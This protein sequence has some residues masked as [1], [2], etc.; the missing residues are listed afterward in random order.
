MR[1]IFPIL[2]TLLLAACSCEEARPVQQPVVD[3]KSDRLYNRAAFVPPQCYTKTEDAAGEAHNPCYVCHQASI[4]PNFVDDADLQLTFAF[5]ETTR[6]NRWSNLFVDR[7]PAMARIS[8]EAILSYVRTSNYLDERGS[9]LLAAKLA[10]PPAAWDVDGDGRWGGWIPDVAF[11]FDERGFDI[12]ADGVPT[13]WRAF[14]Y[15]PFPGTFWPT[16]GSFGDALVRLPAAYRQ[17]ETG[18]YDRGIYEVNLAIAE[19]FAA[20]RDVA[21]PPTDERR[22]G[23][24]LDGDGALGVASLVRYRHTPGRLDLNYLGGAQAIGARDPTRVAPG[25]LPQGTEF[26][27]SVRYLDVVDGKPRMAARMKELRYMRKAGWVTWARL[28]SQAHN[29]AVEKENTPEAVRRFGGTAEYGIGNRA[30]WT[31]TAFIE[32]ARGELRPQSREEHASCIGCHSGIGAT[33]DSVFSFVR[34]LPADSWRGGWYHWTQRGLAGVGEPVRGDGQGEYAHYLEH[35][36]AGDEFRSNA[37]VRA[38]F[39]DETGKLT[40]EARATL[41]R[42]VEA[43]LLPSAARALQLDKTYKLVV[44]EQSFVRGRDAVLA[45]AENVHRELPA[46]EE[47]QPTGVEAVLPGPWHGRTA[48]A[49]RQVVAAE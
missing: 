35:N 11:R 42:D 8:D 34:K 48:A 19:A 20:R 27:H 41:R 6:V 10:A 22:H 3:L 21:I 14:A 26:A 7:R 33:T 44:E 39:F 30:G 32:D 5:S 46:G 31:M 45:P 40:A 25:L 36:G 16:N 18:A 38:R 17:D 2:A 15:H 24:D 9:N 23:V 12:G 49:A 4:P 1:R 47:A 29:E 28:E 43:L 37:E 13:G